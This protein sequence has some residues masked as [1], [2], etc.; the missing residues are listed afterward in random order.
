VKTVKTDAEAALVKLVAPG[1][2]RIDDWYYAMRGTSAAGW[3]YFWSAP[4]SRALSTAS[5]STSTRWRW[6]SRWG[7]GQVHVPEEFSTSIGRKQSM[8]LFDSRAKP[9]L[10]IQYY[11]VEP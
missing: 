11:Q 10:V 7:P 2:R 9:P 8:V 5:V 3:S 1:W 4:R 6:S